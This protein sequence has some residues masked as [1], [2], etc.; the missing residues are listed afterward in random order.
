MKKL[1]LLLSFILSVTVSYSQDTLKTKMAALYT[2]VVQPTSG[3]PGGAKGLIVSG[4]LN[5]PAGVYTVDSVIIGHI[6]WDASGR[7]FKILEINSAV[8]STISV[9][10]EALTDG[11]VEFDTGVGCIQSETG[12]LP[13]AVL[14][15]LSEVAKQAIAIHTSVVDKYDELQYPY[16]VGNK[17][18]LTQSIVPVDLDSLGLSLLADSIRIVDTI[19]GVAVTNMQ[20]AVDALELLTPNLD[21]IPKTTTTTGLVTNTQV[22]YGNSNGKII[23]SPNF[24]YASDKLTIKGATSD[25]LE[26]VVKLRNAANTEILTVRNDNRVGINQT[27]PQATLHVGGNLKLNTLT[28]TA[29]KLGGYTSAN[30]VTEMAVGFGSDIVGGVLRIDTTEV[31]TPHDISV[32]VAASNTIYSANGAIPASTARVATIPANSSLGLQMVGGHEYKFDAT[33]ALFRNP[34]AAGAAAQQISPSTTWEG[35]GWKTDITAASQAVAFRANVTPIQGPANPSGRWALTAAINGGPYSGDIISATSG[36]TVDINDKLTLTMNN[37]GAAYTQAKSFHLRNTTAATLAVNQAP[38]VIVVE[39]TGWKTG[40]PAG[41]STIFGEIGFAP[42]TAGLNASAGFFVRG[43]GITGVI[44]ELI[45]VQTGSGFFNTKVAVGVSNDF[46]A[47][48]GLVLGGFN[49]VSSPGIAIGFEVVA[50]GGA[51]GIGNNVRTTHANAGVVGRHLISGGVDT[52]IFG[53]G[54]SAQETGST[55]FG[56]ALTHFTGGTAQLRVQGLTTV[57]TD[58]WTAAGAVITIT[59]PDVNIAVGQGIA[60]MGT[61]STNV[62]YR[63]IIAVSSTTVFTVSSAPSVASGTHLRTQELNILEVGNGGDSYNQHMIINRS[64]LVGLGITPTSRLTLAAGTTLVAPVQLTSGT[65]LTTPINGAVEFNGTNYFVT[66][67]STRHI[68]S[69]TLTGTGVLNY[70]S[71]ASLA[72]ETLTITVTGAAIGDVVLVGIDNGSKSTGLIFGQPWVS[73]T[74]TVS[75]EAYNSTGS[76][77]DP[78]SGTFRASVIKY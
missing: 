69:K 70:G 12:S 2:V 15:G 4:F 26:A 14:L 20:E 1:L 38:P 35:N 3:G 39:G 53:N 46:N 23:G 8:G 18:Y 42:F 51:L 64:G 68:L 31:A 10:V 19:G 21:S 76:A 30:V 63:T 43:T 75:V 55:N 6:V 57:L 50:S 11:T 36:G 5:D 17:L 77:I 72:T 25:T 29:T 32:A 47:A 33:G 54:P 61:V 34:I 66:T 41:S 74:N 56:T 48:N 62:S 7:R 60:L 73:A 78:A 24:T 44:N 45:N 58:N 27:A 22:L 52:W 9:D 65:N 49:T 67:G 16:L 40:V 28:G 59:T 71:I 37:I 13:V